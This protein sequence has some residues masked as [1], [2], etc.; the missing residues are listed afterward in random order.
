MRS[1]YILLAGADQFPKSFFEGKGIFFRPYDGGSPNALFWN[2][3]YE[4]CAKKGVSVKSYTEWNREKSK[5]DDILLVLNH[6]GETLLWRLY[7]YLRYP[8][9]GG[10][11]LLKR[12]TFFRENYK[13]FKRRIL[14]QLEPLVAMPY[15]YSQLDDV[16][17]AGFYDKIFITSRV[18]NEKWEYFNYFEHRARNIISPHFDASKTKYI[19]MVNSNVRPHSLKGDLYGERLKAIKFFSNSLDFDLYGFYWDLPVRHPLYFGYDKYVKKSWRG[20][21]PDKLKTVSEYKFSICFENGAYPGW[22]SEKIFDCLAAGSIPVYLGAPDIEK[23]VPQDCFVDFRKFGSY[24]ELNKF[25]HNL[26]EKELEEY[27]NRIKKFLSA[28]ADYGKVKKFADKVI[29]V[30]K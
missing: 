23:I 5:P 11:F 1:L 16:V 10:G 15:V 30:I 27:R 25:L 24:A 4:T 26:S 8:K 3:F 14:M 9:A 29:G 7:Y 22:V 6:P 18:S 17:R 19:T 28:P 2:D 20:R 12:R 21:I 13:F